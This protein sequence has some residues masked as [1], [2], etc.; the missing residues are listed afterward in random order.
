MML[1]CDVD[2]RSLIIFPFNFFFLTQWNP[3]W[4][5]CFRWQQNKGSLQISVPLCPFRWG[6]SGSI[7]FPPR[8]FW[9]MHTCWPSC[10]SLH[11]SCKEHSS[12]RPTMWLLRLA[13]SYVGQYRYCT[14]GA[15]YEMKWIEK[16]TSSILWLLYPQT[17]IYNKIMRLCTSN[18]SMGELTVAQICNLV[19]IDTNQLMWFFF[20]CPNLWAMPIQVGNMK[21]YVK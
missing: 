19:A 7:L 14:S 4:F 17:K 6:C 3:A 2:R 8:S 18:M 15:H 16:M 21:I 20:L 12:R 13:S 5:S 1:V 11:C 10:S 9:R